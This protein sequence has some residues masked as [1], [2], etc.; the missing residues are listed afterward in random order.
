M[1]TVIKNRE[2]Q[3]LKYLYADKAIFNSSDSRAFRVYTFAKAETVEKTLKKLKEWGHEGCIA[4]KV[5]EK[6]H[7]QYNVVEQRKTK[8]SDTEKKRMQEL[9]E[10]NSDEYS[11]EFHKW[12]RI[13]TKTCKLSNKVTFYGPCS[14]LDLGKKVA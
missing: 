5:D 14:Q 13:C 11:L 3:L 6:E 1:H 12:C 2:G 4:V 9:I 7:E 10:E 8:E